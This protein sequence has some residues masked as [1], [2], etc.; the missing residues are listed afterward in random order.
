MFVNPNEFELL[1]HLD[2]PGRGEREPQAADAV[3]ALTSMT[4][5]PSPVYTAF[6]PL[7]T[8]AAARFCP[9]LG[10]KFTP[11]P[12]FV[13]QFPQN[14]VSPFLVQDLGYHSHQ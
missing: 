11:S 5:Y 14:I 9:Q 8:A 3:P 6:T 12:S 7:A 4:A 1:Q 13:P 2:V 10:Q